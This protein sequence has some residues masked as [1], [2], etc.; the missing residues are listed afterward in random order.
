MFEVWD[1]RE[2]AKDGRKTVIEALG[3]LVRLAIEEV[4]KSKYRKK[5]HF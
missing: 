4:S 5:V 3:P 2:C 1:L